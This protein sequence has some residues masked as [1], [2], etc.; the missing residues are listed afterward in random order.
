MAKHNVEKMRYA[1]TSYYPRWHSRFGRC[2]AFTT[3]VVG[4]L[5]QRSNS[6]G[7][8]PFGLFVPGERNHIEDLTAIRD[9]VLKTSRMTLRP[10][11]RIGSVAVF[12]S[13]TLMAR[14]TRPIADDLAMHF[15]LYKQDASDYS[16]GQ[17]ERT[18]WQV[19]FGHGERCPPALVDATSRQED[20][21]FTK[22]RSLLQPS[23]WIGSW[24]LDGREVNM[25]ALL[26]FLSSQHVLG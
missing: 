15:L 4:R 8:R 12:L 9:D 19:L 22:F 26:S 18:I 3:R 20:D 7:L 11:P 2:D 1:Q 17:T 21:A 23:A 25:D 24:L 10:T 6:F 14:G 5:W 13:V 16:H